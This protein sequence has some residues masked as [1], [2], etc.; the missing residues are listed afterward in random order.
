M[1]AACCTFENK[2]Y[3]DKGIWRVLN[4]FEKI[5][6]LTWLVYPRGLRK[7]VLEKLVPASH[8]GYYLRE[9]TERKKVAC[10]G[11]GYWQYLPH[12]KR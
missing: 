4:N 6:A 9:L 8:G 2:R 11:R 7:S 1:N 5:I 3:I 10:V 12:A